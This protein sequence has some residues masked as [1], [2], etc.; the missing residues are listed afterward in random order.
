MQSKLTERI[1]KR[2]FVTIVILNII[3]TVIISYSILSNYNKGVI[4]SMSNINI[5]STFILTSINDKEDVLGIINTIKSSYNVDVY[6]LDKNGDS[7]IGDEINLNIKRKKDVDYESNIVILVDNGFNN[8]KGVTVSQMSL[9]NKYFGELVLVKDFT[10]E[11]INTIF[12]LIGI[13]ISQIILI[14]IL[15][16]LISSYI[17]KSLEPLYILKEGIVKYGRGEDVSDLSIITND[18]IE[19]LSKSFIDMGKEVN[20]EKQKTVEFFN[21]ATHELKTPITAISGYV[22]A[23]TK[24]PIEEINIEFRNRAF[25]RMSIESSKLL[26]LVENLLDISRGAVKREYLRE[27]VNILDIT[28][29]CIKSLDNRSIRNSFIIKSNE[30]IINANKDDITTIIYNLI[31]NAIKYSKSED[32]KIT[33]GDRDT[34]FKI[35]NEIYKIPEDK[36]DKLLEP[37]MKYNFKL[38]QNREE[39]ISSSGL[40]LYLCYNL[41]QTNNLKLSYE[42][43]NNIIT[44]KLSELY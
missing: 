8:S 29:D 23:L 22:Q 5:S 43:I 26:I 14:L 39:K 21:N 33:I 31:D 20:L 44:F 3:L 32:I 2:I 42:I 30:I 4:N 40:G 1:T 37:F 28:K 19:E 35:E 24:K 17:R 18:E 36:K 7:I 27:D 12:T 10:S 11:Y 13:V 41:A 25:Y 15:L 16:K 6:I 38:E 9:N 34:I